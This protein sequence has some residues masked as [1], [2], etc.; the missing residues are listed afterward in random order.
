M[1][2]NLKKIIEQSKYPFAGIEPFTSLAPKLA[3]EEYQE[4][5]SL[6]KS[7]C[8]FINSLYK[9]EGA[10]FLFKKLAPIA[11]MIRDK[12]E[13]HR[14]ILKELAIDITRDLFEVPQHVKFSIKF[15]DAKLISPHYQNA[16]F[17]PFLSEKR[18]EFIH[19]QINKRI[20]I[21]S[22]VHGSAMHIWK[23]AHYIISER[24]KQIDPT[25]IAFYDSY[26]AI[27]SFINV[28]LF[29]GGNEEIVSGGHGISE[30][31]FKENIEVNI[32]ATNFITCIHEVVKS[33]FDII[34]CYGLSEELSEQELEY[35]YAKAD[36]Y[37]H[38]VWH[39][40]FGPSLWRMFIEKENV[41]S[42]TLPEKFMILCNKSYADITQYFEI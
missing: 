29:E 28:S 42:Q 23:S 14:D 18:K 1:N 30:I 9:G 25:L 12:E 17:T 19:E 22:L 5:F 39:Y 34:A 31:K 41:S 27:S 36:S 26:S 16:K 8:P 38:E 20:V 13:K 6:F 37:E 10:G 21:N 32:K 24:L 4:A 2:I 33:S 3:E 7:K 15:T 11:N 40:I 35:V